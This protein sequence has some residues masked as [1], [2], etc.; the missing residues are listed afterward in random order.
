MSQS[1]DTQM[2]FRSGHNEGDTIDQE[3]AIYGARRPR[4]YGPR[5]QHP[6]HRSASVTLQRP[7]LEIIRRQKLQYI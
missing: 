1:R 7:M 5:P 4:P 6:C 2:G 3:I